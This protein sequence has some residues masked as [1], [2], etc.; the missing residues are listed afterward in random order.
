MMNKVIYFACDAG[1]GSSAMG[2][3]LLK[4]AARQQG[5]SLCIKNCSIFE[6]PK[7]A[8]I[9]CCHDHYESYARNRYPWSQIY[10][11]TNFMEVSQYERMINKMIQK[12][13]LTTLNMDGIILNCKA[14]SSDEAI[15][16][17]GK[18][19]VKQG[20][21][22]EHYIEGMLKRDHSLTTYIGNDIAI[23]HGEFEYIS[24]IIKTGLA[25]MIYPE[26]ISWGGGNVRVVIGI[27]AKNDEHMETLS[28]IAS[29]FC[30]MDAVEQLVRCTNVLD[31]Y[32][33]LTREEA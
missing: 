5:I 18:L 22:N 33:L 23:P 9:V 8:S 28:I 7:D 31:A 1:L 19:L 17:V 3:S 4:K 11:V 6:V 27:A 20:Y 25:V 2:S 16:E 14:S 29:K 15:I 30:E 26:G 12:S 10:S 24:D 13:G 21:V 32:E